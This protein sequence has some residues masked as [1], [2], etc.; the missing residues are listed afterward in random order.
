MQMYRCVVRLAGT[1][2]N[3]VPKPS[4]SAPEIAVL[5][6]MHGPDSVVR[7]SKTV[8]DKRPHREERKRLILLYGAGK[9]EKLFPGE[10][11][12][13]PVRLEDLGD[14]PAAPAEEPAEAEEVAA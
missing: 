11:S 14:A 13:L 6:S 1:V 12:R 9:I 5:R 2:N 10:F 4:V 8:M 7:I 3:E